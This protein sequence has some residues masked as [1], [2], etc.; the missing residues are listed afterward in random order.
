M[1]VEVL[2]VALFLR[3]ESTLSPSGLASMVHKFGS[4]SID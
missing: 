1:L 4:G 2:T 3:W